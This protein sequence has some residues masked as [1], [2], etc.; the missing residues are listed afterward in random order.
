MFDILYFQT[1][2]YELFDRIK[3]INTPTKTSITIILIK[4]KNRA[5]C[6]SNFKGIY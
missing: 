5:F 1:N 2:Q 3:N 4:K 6:E